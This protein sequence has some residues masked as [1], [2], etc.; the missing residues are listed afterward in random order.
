MVNYKIDSK[1][2][3]VYLSIA[4]IFVGLIMVLFLMKI[5]DTV[6]SDSVEKRVRSI[7]DFINSFHE[8]AERAGYISG[9]RSFVA[10]EDYI[11]ESGAFV[12]NSEE[13]FKELFY[14]GTYNGSNSS[15]MKNSSFDLY[16]SKVE[17]ISSNLNLDFNFEIIDV[18]FYQLDPWNV[19]INLTATIVVVDLKGSAN[20]T[21][22][23]VLS[24]DVP[25]YNLKD[26]LYSVYAAGRI[27]N[28]ILE[29][30]N[31]DFVNVSDN[32]TLV[33][34]KHLNG[35]Y[36]IASN[37]SPSFMMRFEGDTDASP[38][39]IES[40][41]NIPLLE[42]QDLTVYTDRSLVD[43]IYF[44][45]KSHTLICDVQNEPYDWFALDLARVA[46]Y[47]ID[48]LNYTIC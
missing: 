27:Q 33:L 34:E 45:G 23:Q 42:S 6:S 32:T 21:Y 16:I 18:S 3:I 15:I 8:D 13:I 1:R 41:V 5:K 48:L 31:I 20:W 25:I 43:H 36:Y 40:L 2:G 12:N 30:E 7:N 44:E 46:D 11:S 17:D 22:D 28:F 14:N 47:Q 38:Y 35:S 26:P 39:G 19:Y 24:F 29:S 37:K 9:Y 4:I 10:L